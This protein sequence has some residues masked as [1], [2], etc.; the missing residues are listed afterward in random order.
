MPD[1]DDPN[2][3]TLHTVE[4]P[5][6]ANDDFSV[7]KVRELREVASRV[8]KPLEAAK[9]PLGSLAK[10]TGRVWVLAVDVGDDREELSPARRREAYAHAYSESRMSSASRST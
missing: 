2:V 10:A 6:A 8:R 9:N 7:R 4:E 5:V 3:P 1:R